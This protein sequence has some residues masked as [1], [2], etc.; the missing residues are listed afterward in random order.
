[1]HV[2]ESLVGHE[3]LLAGLWRN[4]RKGRLPHALLFEGRSGVGKFAA[5][6]RLAAG[7]LCAQGPGPACR[8]CPPC[9]RVQSGGW[10]GNHPDLYTIDPLEEVLEEPESK[11]GSL[12]IRLERISVRDGNQDCAEGFL[13]LVSVEGGWRIVLVREAHLMIVAAQNALLKTLEEPGRD[14]LIVLETALSSELLPTIRSRCVRVRFRALDLESSAAILVKEG[15]DVAR[16][17]MLA[18]WSRGAPGE[19]LRLHREGADAARAVLL[20]VLR[21][22]RPTLEA[23][24]AISEL[25]GDFPGPSAPARARA[26]ARSFLDLAVCVLAD[27]RRAAEGVATEGLAHGDVAPELARAV[28]SPR[29]RRALDQALDLCGVMEANVTPELTVERL[30]LVLRE[31]IGV[32]SRAAVSRVAP[33]T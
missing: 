21:G 6:R 19:G 10:R 20:D 3:A 29:G 31:A 23:V 12:A 4:A 14:T 13:G 2:P 16:A 15:L 5:A 9:K 24:R 28:L 8:T 7:L 1:M 11:R 27:A 22:S 25:E 33:R 18:R 32:P 26:R 30:L 17:R